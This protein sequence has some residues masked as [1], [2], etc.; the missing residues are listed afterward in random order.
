MLKLNTMKVNSLSI[1]FPAFNDSESLPILIDKAFKAASKITNNF[2]VIVVD[3]GSTDDTYSVLKNMQTS[4]LNLRIIHHNKNIGYG[5]ALISGFRNSK[6]DWV[7]YTDGDSQYDVQELPRLTNAVNENID[8]VNGYKIRRSDNLIRKF[9]GSVYN[10]LLHKLY[11]LPISDV[12]C[13]F[14][15]IRR[16]IMKNIQLSSTSGIICL[17]LVLKLNKAGA[18]FKEVGVHHYKRQFGRSK[19]FKPQSIIKTV[20]D[21][22]LFYFNS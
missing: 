17:E 16:S 1:F 6:K 21:N 13:D 7:F 3:D 9:I 8:V 5:G 12:D 4:Y 22:M 19:F 11:D 14:R 10:F 20:I 18:R 2:E 15:L